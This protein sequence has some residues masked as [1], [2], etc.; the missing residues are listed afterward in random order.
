MEGASQ[1]SSSPRLTSGHVTL[2]DMQDHELWHS[3]RTALVVRAGV[4]L[5]P[6]APS[7]LPSVWGGGVFVPG[8]RVHPPQGTGAAVQSPGTMESS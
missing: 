5:R 2:G 8:A 1:R 6:A 7:S 4:H 3:D